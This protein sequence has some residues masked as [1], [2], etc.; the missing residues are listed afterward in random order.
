MIAVAVSSFV[1]VNLRVL[2]ALSLFSQYLALCSLTVL[3]QYL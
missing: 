2:F 3:L 1:A